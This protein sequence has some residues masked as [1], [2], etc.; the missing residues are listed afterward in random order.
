RLGDVRSRAMTLYKMA[1]SLLAAGD[2]TD[3]RAQ[4]IHA[5]ASESF[6]IASRLNLPDG[7]GHAGLL[8][9]E[10]LGRTGRVKEALPIL[11]DAKAAF[12]R[13]GDSVGLALVKR[14]RRALS[15]AAR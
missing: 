9:A 14:L 6:V 3:G 2:L 15:R 10:L 5:A 1:A 11:D 4:E 8:L 12:T 7:I 13:L